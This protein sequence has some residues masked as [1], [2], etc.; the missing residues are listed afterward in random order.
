M[1]MEIVPGDAN[2]TKDG[3]KLGG[4]AIA[5]LGGLGLLVVFMIQN[6]DDVTV[7]FLVWDFTWPVW[8]LTLVTALVGAFVWVGLG[9]LRRHRRRKARR[10]RTSRLTCPDGRRHCVAPAPDRSANDSSG[11]Q[12]S[13]QV[14]HDPVHLHQQRGVV[15]AIR[16]RAGRLPVLRRARGPAGPGATRPAR[17][18]PGASGPRSSDRARSASADAPS[19]SCT[20]T[21]TAFANATRSAPM[22]GIAGCVVPTRR[23]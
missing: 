8:L 23:A 13:A 1:S 18:P 20:N 19:T 2:S 6:T 21:R 11:R 16:P 9:V 3:F 7:E 10:A 12:R 5:S 14:A 4:G 22:A 17:T 15:R